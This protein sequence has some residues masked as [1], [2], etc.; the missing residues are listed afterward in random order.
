MR[1]AGV[2]SSH[3]FA[4]LA[5]VRMTKLPGVKPREAAAVLIRAGFEYVRQSGSHRI[6][7]KGSIGVTVPWHSRDLRKGTLR[8]IIRQAGLTPEE[9]VRFLR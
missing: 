5:E 8:Q 9:F 4:S 2:S 1:A 7:V 3:R 6:Y